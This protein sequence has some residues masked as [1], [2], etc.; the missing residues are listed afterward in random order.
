MAPSDR[1][2]ALVRRILRGSLLIALIGA[3]A[4]RANGQFFQQAVGGISIDAAGVLSNAEKDHNGLR[5]MWLDNLQ[6]IAGELNAPAKLRKISLRGIEKQLAEIARTEGRLPDDLRFL[7][8]LQRIEYV[9]VYPEQNDVVLAGY[10]EGWQ[11]DDRGN[12]VG[13]T[14][15]RPIMQLDDLLVALRTADAAAR[16]GI[17]CSIDPSAE[18]LARIQN[19]GDKLVQTGVQTGGNPHAVADEIARELGPQAITFHG[20]PADSRFAHVLLGADYRMK[21]L[22]MNFDPS[23]VKGFSS[24]LHLLKSANRPGLQNML[25]RWWMTTN[26]EPLLTD[27][28]GLAWQLR[29]QGVKTMSENDLLAGDGSRKQTGKSSPIAQKWADQMTRKYEELSLKEPIFG[30]LRNCMDLAVVAA[31]IFKEDLLVKASL[32][33]ATLLSPDRYATHRYKTPKQVDSKASVLEARSGYILSA[34]GGVQI[35][36][37]ADASRKEVSEELASTRAQ[38]EEGRGDRWWWN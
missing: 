32:D 11:V 34:S 23:P 6:P 14:T 37:W 7:A 30:E 9:L 18:G 35:N 24:Y 13:A 28:D 22:G 36:S 19:M 38:A 33:L 8:G 20:V 27:G 29:G 2:A 26:Y 16:G 15:G 5:Q 4:V 12:M 17:T 3:P 31:L 25:P 10:A 1:G 21:R